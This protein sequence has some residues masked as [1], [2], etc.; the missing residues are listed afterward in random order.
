MT[1][2]LFAYFCYNLYGDIMEKL[3]NILSDIFLFKLDKKVIDK[4][5]IITLSMISILFLMPDLL[6]EITKSVNELYTSLYIIVMIPLTYLFIYN[7][8]KIKKIDIIV[9]LV[10]ILILLISS[11]F[12]YN[13]IIA[14]LG[15]GRKEGFITFLMYLLIYINARNIT[16]EGFYILIKVFI[17]IV[18]INF[19]FGL[20]QVY[21]NVNII[22]SKTFYGMAYGFAG[23]PNFYGTLMVLFSSFFIG[24]YLY[25][26]KTIYLITHI[27]AFIGIILS[28]STGPF[29]TMVLL[30]IILIIY[31]FIHK[32]E[33]LKKIF[34]L[35]PIYIIL[36]YLVSRSSVYINKI[37]YKGDWKYENYSIKNDFD[38]YKHDGSLLAKLSKMSN[39]RIDL[40]VD[41]I[42]YIDR[43]D[44]ILL[45]SG[46]ENFSIYRLTIEDNTVH[47][48]LRYDKTHNI[49]LNIL[50]ETGI[51]SLI[52]YLIWIFIYHKK[53]INSK[54]MLST[55][56]LFS[57]IGYNIQGL[58]N[59]NV[60]QVSIYYYMFIGIAL[61][62][63]DKIETRK[64]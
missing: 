40:W 21:L 39:G 4:L 17:G 42:K 20:I 15:G 36:Y 59:I 38:I 28:S 16:K 62:L 10:Y 41:S 6:Y 46:L 55:I 47:N 27:I 8:K 61:G 37:F 50:V 29:L 23:N 60:Y 44:S 11:I 57:L 32:K 49:Y 45:G 3:R 25:E 63:G 52:V 56:L 5:N 34:I 43:N 51:F 1:L 22:S 7:I 24:L 18:F 19:I 9:F 48:L 64:Y 2:F 35:I 31:L 33:L 26:G 54:N 13:P 58:F 12:A 30:F 14:F 53:I